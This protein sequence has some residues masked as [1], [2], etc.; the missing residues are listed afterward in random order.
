MRRG[1]LNKPGA[2]SVTTQSEADRISSKISNLSVSE[3][4]PKSDSNALPCVLNRSLMRLWQNATERGTEPGSLGWPIDTPQL[5]PRITSADAFVDVYWKLGRPGLTVRGCK[6]HRSLP[7]DPAFCAWLSY[8]DVYD[9]I[10]NIGWAELWSIPTSFP[11][12]IQT[13]NGSGLGMVA[14]RA[15]AAGETICIERPVLISPSALPSHKECPLEDRLQDIYQTMLGVLDPGAVTAIMSLS[16]CKPVTKDSWS[17]LRGIIDTN[18]LY[19]SFPQSQ[20][21]P[22]YGG[23]FLDMS[24][25]NHSCAPNATWDWD[26][27]SLSM[28]FRA[29]RPIREGEEITISYLCP[30]KSRSER[31]KE[32][33]TKYNFS[34]TCPAC[35]PPMPS[36]SHANA[37]SS[38]T[39]K[40]KSTTHLSAKEAAI[41]ASDAHRKIIGDSNIIA[42]T[43]W[44]HW[45]SPTSTQPSTKITEFHERILQLRDEEGYQN[46]SEDNYA[47]LAHACAALGDKEGFRRWAKKLM[48][49]RPWGP[50]LPGLDK[51][52]TW[53]GWVEDPTKSPAWGLR[54]TANNYAIDDILEP[55]SFTQ[56]I[57]IRL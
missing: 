45:A 35:E 9:K 21:L 14:I 53:E 39:T 17:R 3:N 44:K 11:Y 22:H 56:I 2:F 27:C 37:S 40:A 30:W 18:T 51:Q 7:T 15:I 33:K 6:D 47:Y 28:E 38:R 4:S 26:H 52:M 1:F 20:Y 57:I 41:A 49:W 36:E 10:P 42:G 34:C 54:E 46:E 43:L 25:C 23:V 24:R 32:L 50:G 19:C 48:E 5:A 16:N 55:L 12:R 8:N 29:L 31:Q 13:V